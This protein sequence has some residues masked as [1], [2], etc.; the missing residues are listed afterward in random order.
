MWPTLEDL[1]EPKDKSVWAQWSAPFFKAYRDGRI[2]TSEMAE[3]IGFYTNM[4]GRPHWETI[5]KSFVKV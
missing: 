3:A 2:A 1:A 5:W 4:Y